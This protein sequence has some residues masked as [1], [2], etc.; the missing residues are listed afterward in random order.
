MVELKILVGCETS[1]EVRESFRSLGHD[2]WSLDIYGSDDA[3]D[4]HIIGDVKE[5]LYMGWD[6]I[7]LHPPCT[8]LAVSGN[9]Y[10][11]KGG[12]KHSERLLA[13]E[14]TV[15]LWFKATGAC[16]H[17][18]M[19]NPVGD[20]PL[21]ASQY[22]QPYEYGHA[23]SKKTCLWLHGLPRLRPENIVKL[24]DRG[25]WDNQTPSGQNKIPPIKDRAKLRSKTYSG[26][27]KAMANQWGTFVQKERENA[28]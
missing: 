23:E 10:Y 20:L 21:G 17:V 12:P 14:W 15:D 5:H 27:A 26:V 25:F 22:I 7:I 3:S 13:Q 18:A 19:E 24:P 2:A 1:G 28:Y 8:A 4:F 6:I 16:P 11:G 9:R